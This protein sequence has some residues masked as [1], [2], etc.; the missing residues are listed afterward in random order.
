MFLAAVTTLK[1]KA[2]AS[3]TAPKGEPTQGTLCLLY[4]SSFI[5]G[6]LHYRSYFSHNY[7]EQWQTDNLQVSRI[8]LPQCFSIHTSLTFSSAWPIADQALTQEILDIVQQASNYRQLKKG[9]N[10]SVTLEIA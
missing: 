1:R 5:F 3:T 10:E 8:L 4:F 7:L 2:K 9:A 6:Q